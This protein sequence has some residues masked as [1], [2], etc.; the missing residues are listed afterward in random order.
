MMSYRGKRPGT[1]EQDIERAREEGNWRKVVELAN[2]L[3]DRLDRDKPNEALGWFLIGEGKLEEYLEENPPVLDNPIHIETLSKTKLKEAKS[4]LEKVLGED[5]AKIGVHLDS[6]I[7]LAKLNFAMGNYAESLR[8]YEKSKLETLE[9]KQLPP[10]SLKIIAEAFAI[11]GLCIEKMAANSTSALSRNRMA[12]NDAKIIKN[13]EVAGDLTL[14]YLQEI[15][16]VS[17]RG[18]AQSTL[19]MQSVGTSNSPVPPNVEHKLGPILELA[20]LKAP[21]LYIK[22]GHVNKAISRFRAM[23][24]AEETRSTSN[25]RLSLAKQ[26]AE[27]L[28]HSIT[29]SRYHPPDTESPRRVNSRQNLGVNNI[30]ES[31]WKPRKYSNTNQF[32]PTNKQEEIVLLLMLC[33]VMAS[34]HV[35]LNQNPEYDA[36]R[37]NTL[38]GAISVFHLMNLALARYGYYRTLCEMF[39]RSLRYA[40]K[41][42]HIWSQFALVLACDGRYL[43][44]VVIL[45][46]VAEMNE[47]DASPCLLGARLCYEK[48]NLLAEGIEWAEKALEREEDYPQDLKARCHLYIGI[49][50]YLKATEVE[51][52]ESRQ[53]YSNSALQHLQLSIELDPGDH[54]AHFYLGLHLATNR[55]LTE[56]YHVANKALHLNPEHLQSLHLTALILSAKGELDEALKLTDY[57]LSEYPDHLPL[58][59]LKARLEEE[60]VGA[61]AALTTTRFMFG[62]LR[63]LTDHANSNSTDSGIGTEDNKSMVPS[64]SYWDTLSDK[65]SVS[66]Q[67]QSVAASQVEKTLSEVASSLSANWNK[68]HSQEASYNIIRTWV[69]TAELYLKLDQV[70]SAQSCCNEATQLYPLSY[71]IL[72]LKGKIHQHQQQWHEAKACFEDSLSINPNHIPSLQELGI[73]QLRRGSPRLA[74]TALRSAIRLHPHDPVSWSN[75]GLV[76]ESLEGESETAANCF[77]TAQET[78]ETSPILPFNTISLAFE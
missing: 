27:T 41:E 73:T 55:K 9:E 67:A 59:A 33:E 4:C 69:L 57:A 23:L 70:E 24:S 39:E 45:K 22:A 3:K 14:L 61:E 17:R 50:H 15:D 26:L 16:K 63:H 49:G 20:L 11:K 44:S 48:L 37:A 74:E 28:M 53:K 5:A 54:L 6:W 38:Q 34:K 13:F 30:G 62:L 46:E 76:M 1:L 12:E 43:R 68:N 78:K 52:R 18:Y 72:Y 65:D 31:P 40:P 36:H 60:T 47:K 21:Q 25:V 51:T 2:Q 8:F 56:A 64:Y 35:P 32:V 42:E 29:D 66:L 10:R 71:H 75:F 19:S 7:L 77:A 58:L